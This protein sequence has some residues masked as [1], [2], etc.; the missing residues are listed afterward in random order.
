MNFYI[1]IFIAKS[2]LIIIYFLF[3]LIKVLTFNS[4]NKKLEIKFSNLIISILKVL[5]KTNK[6]QTFKE[7][8]KEDIYPLQ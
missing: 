7:K 8:I 5:I 3:Y 4:L 2:L 6:K 1:K